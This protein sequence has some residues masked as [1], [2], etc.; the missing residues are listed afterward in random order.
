ME[1][2]TIKNLRFH[3]GH[4]YFPAEREKGNDFEVDITIWLEL[5]AAATGDDLAAT[6]DY[7]EAAE[8]AGD[9][10]NGEPVK[11]VETLLYR[12]GESLTR[13]YPKAENI[14]VAVRKL[15]PP[16]EPSCE[17]TEV[18]SRWPRL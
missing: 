5:E 13:A 16:M 7:G 18:R 17:F 10:M 9:I 1:C 8:I 2:I 12:I 14:E 4:G 15:N 3:A 11:L 6:I